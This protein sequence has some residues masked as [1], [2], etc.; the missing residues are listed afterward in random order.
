MNEYAVMPLSDYVDVCDTI[1]KHLHIPDK[2]PSHS[3]PQ[4]IDEVFQQGANEAYGPAYDKG[5]K[6]GKT[7]VYSEIEPINAQLENT[8]NG[9]DTGGKSY[10]DEFWDVFQNDG[11]RT[12]YTY[13]FSRWNVPYI[14]PK[15]KVI[16]TESSLDNTF[17]CNSALLKIEA[18][19]FDFSLSY[20]RAHY[21]FWKCPE[22]QEIEDIKLSPSV[23]IH[24]F[25]DCPK[26]HTIAKIVLD[27]NTT[28][29]MPIHYCGALENLTI[30]G[31]IG[32]NG[33]NVQW[34]TKLTHNSLMSI[35]NALKDFSGTSTWRAIT[36]G[37][38]NLAKLTAEELNAM[39]SKQW[40][41]S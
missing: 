26:L 22:L 28:Y 23:M 35:I 3:V 17:S 27:E 36:L 25:S 1:R 11:N 10:Y 4:K 7:E 40:E 6:Y 29:D 2:I 39:T 18:K 19:Y 14:Q 8:L 34:S 21:T 33:F 24:P 13:A 32:Q 31:T 30:E 41:Y 9:T 20:S 5:C 38:E 15:Y 37:S 12:S 16:P